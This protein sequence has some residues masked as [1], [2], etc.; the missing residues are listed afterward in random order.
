M[1]I[2]KA[3]CGKRYSRKSITWAVS[4]FVLVLIVAWGSWSANWPPNYVYDGL[5][6]LIVLVL[7]GTI[8][9]KKIT[10][11]ETNNGSQN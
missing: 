8:I 11:K 1:N 4:L 6:A 7:T 9:D 3:P 2:L 10:D 5:I